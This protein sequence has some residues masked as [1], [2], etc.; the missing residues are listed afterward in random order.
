MSSSDWLAAMKKKL[1]IMDEMHVYKLA[2]LPAGHKA[3]GN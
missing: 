2:P 1:N 3:I